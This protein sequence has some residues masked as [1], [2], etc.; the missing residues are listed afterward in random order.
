VKNKTTVADNDLIDAVALSKILLVDRQTIY[1]K[2]RAGNIPHIRLSAKWVRFKRGAIARW[3]E[4]HA[5]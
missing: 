4:Q 3:L 5:A 1:K 2:V